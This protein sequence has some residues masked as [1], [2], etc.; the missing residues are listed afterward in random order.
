MKYSTLSKEFYSTYT[1]Y[2]IEW[3]KVIEEEA[4]VQEYLSALGKKE[5]K[6]SKEWGQKIPAD[7]KLFQ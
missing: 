5:T 7:K 6:P 3:V 1:N 4:G 2:F